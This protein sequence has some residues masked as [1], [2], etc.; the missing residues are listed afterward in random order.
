MKQ[1]FRT[2]LEQALAQTGIPLLQI[3]NRSGVSY[4]QLKK[5]LQKPTATT[6]VDSAVKVAAAF[7]VGLDE[8]LDG[9]IGTAPPPPEP[10]QKSGFSEESVAFQSRPDQTSAVRALFCPSASH[11]QILSRQLVNLPG[12]G[13]LRGDLA[14]VDLGREAHS[15]DLVSV[16][17]TEGTRTSTVLRR[18][19]AP[20]LLACDAALDNPPLRDDDPSVAIRY[21]VIGLVRGAAPD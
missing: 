19:L 20:L 4:D 15:G 3:A 12:L 2:A 6:N 17:I 13:F 5:L 21:P 11:P 7:G 1:T 16:S 8:F 9:K 18:Y 10:A 14:V